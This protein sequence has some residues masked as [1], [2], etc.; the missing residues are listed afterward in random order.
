MTNTAFV[1]SQWKE[2]L[3]YYV[4]MNRTEEQLLVAEAT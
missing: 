2:R 3:P 1:F 4:L